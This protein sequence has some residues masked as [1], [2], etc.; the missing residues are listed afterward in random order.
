MIQSLCISRTIILFKKKIYK[1]RERKSKKQECN[2]EKMPP[3]E[4]IFYRKISQ[5]H[6]GADLVKMTMTIL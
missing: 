4:S 6:S 3:A 2:R 1:G 5:V